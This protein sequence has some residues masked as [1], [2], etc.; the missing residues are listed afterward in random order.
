MFKHSVPGTLFMPH[1][2]R[3]NYLYSFSLVLHKKERVS[4]ALVE[5]VIKQTSHF[6]LYLEYNSII[7]LFSKNVMWNFNGLST[8]YS[9]LSTASKVYKKDETNKIEYL[10]WTES[11]IFV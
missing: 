10:S 3:Y 5:V 6:V 11:L 8:V 4:Q 7:Y 9:T 2:R 1:Q